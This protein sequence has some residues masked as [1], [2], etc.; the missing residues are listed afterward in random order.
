MEVLRTEV[1]IDPDIYELVPGFCEARKKELGTIEEHLNNG[2]FKAVAKISHS[3]KG[4][5]A[6]FGFPTLEKLFR[7]LE[8]VVEAQNA[9]EA[10][11][12]LMLIRQYFELYCQ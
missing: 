11:R 9:E 10:R 8:D 12:Y 5:A 6:P 4:I 1:P 7:S 3:V 2:N